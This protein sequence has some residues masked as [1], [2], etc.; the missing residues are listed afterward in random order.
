MVKVEPNLSQ[1]LPGGSRK[2]ALEFLERLHWHLNTKEFEG[3]VILFR[4]DTPIFSADSKDALD[5]FV[6]GAYLAYR[7]LPESVFRNYKEQ[8]EAL[9]TNHANIPGLTPLS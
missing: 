5:G 2:G 8:M 4:G 3:R 6:Y 1:R 7:S 9:T